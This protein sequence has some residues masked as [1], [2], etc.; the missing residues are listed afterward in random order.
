MPLEKTN[1]TAQKDIFFNLRGCSKE[2]LKY[3]T[4]LFSLSEDNKKIKNTYYTLSH[5]RYGSQSGV[6]IETDD[7]YIYMYKRCRNHWQNIGSRNGIAGCCATM[8]MKKIKMHKFYGDGNV[9]VDTDNNLYFCDCQK[10]IKVNLNKLHTD[11]REVIWVSDNVVFYGDYLLF[12][13]ICVP[14]PEKYR[15]LYFEQIKNTLKIS[16]INNQYI[17]RYSNLDSF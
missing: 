3:F 2:Y 12:E 1:S 8:K 4:T 15:D 6:M 5:S 13:Y 17:C 10:T 7:G 11:V 16:N 9:L 14:F